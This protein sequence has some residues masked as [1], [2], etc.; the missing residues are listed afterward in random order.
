MI[1]ALK[2]CTILVLLSGAIK[3]LY[4]QAIKF[5]GWKKI[6]DP[7][8]VIVS[9]LDGIENFCSGQNDFIS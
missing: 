1:L 4:Y 7:V 8:G 9:S 5:E 6:A 3:N 2:I